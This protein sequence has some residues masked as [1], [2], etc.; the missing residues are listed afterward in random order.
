MPVDGAL[1]RIRLVA[2]KMISN[3]AQDSRLSSSWV[4][5]SGLKAIC[6]RTATMATMTMIDSAGNSHILT[7]S[8]SGVVRRRRIT[9]EMAISR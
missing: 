7:T 1:S 4:R 2:K 8:L 5:V 3:S 6:R 9:C